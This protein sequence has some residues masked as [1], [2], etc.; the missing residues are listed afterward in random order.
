MTRKSTEY[1]L[2]SLENY[3]NTALQPIHPRQEFISH[4]RHRVSSPISEQAIEV[5][6]T[7]LLI[8]IMLG[9]ASGTLLI[10][11]AVRLVVNLRQSYRIVRHR[12]K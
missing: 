8:Y 3:L 1:D 9:L 7:R 10:I 6:F 4:M 2:T 11:T 12:Q 5:N